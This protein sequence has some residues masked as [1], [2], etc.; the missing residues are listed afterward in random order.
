[1]SGVREQVV[2]VK[3]AAELRGLTESE[4][5]ERL[6]GKARFHRLNGELVV[7]RDDLAKALKAGIMPRANSSTEDRTADAAAFLGLD[8]DGS[9][10]SENST[11]PA[12]PEPIPDPLAPAPDPV[13]E[14]RTKEAAKALGIDLK[15]ASISSTDKPAEQ[16]RQAGS[17]VT[18]RA[19]DTSYRLGR[20]RRWGA[21]T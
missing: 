16:G 12:T 17:P 9:T 19:D 10:S 4:C 14:A 13:V 8:I 21:T 6:K 18:V 2:K 7:N 11:G 1:V 3:D 5:V 20:P 15:P